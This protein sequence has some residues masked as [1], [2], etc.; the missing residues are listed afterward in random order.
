MDDESEEGEAAEGQY[1][2][3]SEYVRMGVLLML[4]SIQA[5]AVD[6]LESGTREHDPE[7]PPH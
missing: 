2:E 3:V 6:A 5:R 4:A 7:T 1:A